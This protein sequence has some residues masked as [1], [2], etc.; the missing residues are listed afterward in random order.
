MKLKTD[1]VHLI[2]CKLASDFKHSY[3]FPDFL[4][5]QQICPVNQLEF[6]KSTVS[7]IHFSI[8]N[9]SIRIFQAT[10]PGTMYLLNGI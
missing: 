3:A 8:D 5:T 1:N 10:F 4:H 7:V 2:I 9:D 6:A